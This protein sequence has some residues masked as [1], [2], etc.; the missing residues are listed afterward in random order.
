MGG[1]AKSHHHSKKKEATSALPL[2][3]TSHQ[4]KGFAYITSFTISTT[5]GVGITGPI[6]YL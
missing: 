3:F 2:L 6:L 1:S 4:A 5:F